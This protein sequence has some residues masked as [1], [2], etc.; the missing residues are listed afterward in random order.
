MLLICQILDHISEYGYG[1]CM[2]GQ[3]H[4]LVIVILWKNEP[5]ESFV[6]SFIS[7]LTLSS[8]QLVCEFSHS[9]RTAY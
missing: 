7:Q 8:N 4:I 9:F 1:V 3:Q 6:I 2:K 5:F